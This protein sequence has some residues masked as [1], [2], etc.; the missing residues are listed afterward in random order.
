MDSKFTFSLNENG[1]LYGKGFPPA[2]IDN[3]IIMRANGDNNFLDAGIVENSLVFINTKLKFIEGGL[4][5]FKLSE[6]KYKIS[7]KEIKGEYFGRVFMTINTY[8]D[9]GRW[10]LL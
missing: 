5:I 10:N 1:V 3:S 2:F 4:N 7:R 8:D 9:I 6:D